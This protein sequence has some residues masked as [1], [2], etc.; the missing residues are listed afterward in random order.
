MI[1][2]TYLDII[3]NDEQNS[4]KITPGDIIT[5]DII[6][7]LRLGNKRTRDA[8]FARVSGNPN[9]IRYK[10]EFVCLLC[11]NTTCE[12]FT[13]QEIL[14]HLE[15]NLP[16]KCSMCKSRDVAVDN[17]TEVQINAIAQSTLSFIDKYLVPTTAN[18]YPEYAETQLAAF[19]R[20]LRTIDESKVAEVIQAMSYENFLQTLY[21]KSVS[22]IVKQNNNHRCVLCSSNDSLAVHHNTY[23]NHGYEHK[24]YV[25]KY[26][27][28]TLCENCHSSFHK[29][30]N[31]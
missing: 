15:K 3:L 18:I 12:E 1:N 29:H 8:C 28:T 25:I 26:D 20:Y 14:E 4:S 7:L 24:D 13:K 22:Y 27:L 16:L 6:T 2:K 23:M 31:P 17:F 10:V 9:S 19:K 21:W 30:F 5:E 11:G